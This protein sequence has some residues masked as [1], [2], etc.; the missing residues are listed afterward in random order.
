LR[1]SVGRPREAELLWKHQ[2]EINDILADD[3]QNIVV[4]RRQPLLIIH[5]ASV[6]LFVFPITARQLAKTTAPA[7]PHRLKAN[8]RAWRDWGELRYLNF[9]SWQEYAAVSIG[10]VPVGCH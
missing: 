10:L 2:E 7:L 1:G 8:G 5:P 3:C 4:L 9:W 6:F